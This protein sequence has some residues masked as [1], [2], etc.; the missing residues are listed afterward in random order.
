MRALSLGPGHLL[1]AGHLLA[2]WVSA[3]SPPSE[4]QQTT[5]LQ[6]RETAWRG[7]VSAPAQ[8]PRC[9]GTH[10]PTVAGVSVP[11]WLWLPPGCPQDWLKV[12]VG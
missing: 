2:L 4:P 5:A 6:G 12:L 3:G 8:M 7:G 1:P 10:S 9:R 11:Q